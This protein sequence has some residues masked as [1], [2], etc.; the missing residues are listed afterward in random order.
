[1]REQV[2]SLVEVQ[3]RQRP[4]RRADAQCRAAGQGSRFAGNRLVFAKQSAG[5]VL[6]RLP[7]P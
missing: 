5:R 4:Y 2:G 6:A 3:R 1:L 7:E